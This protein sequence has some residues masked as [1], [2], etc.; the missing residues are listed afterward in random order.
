MPSPFST[1][2]KW[3]IIFLYYDGF[4]TRQVAK[5]L[6]MS[7]FTVKKVLGIYRKWGCI[8]DPWIKK[9]GRRKIFNGNDMKASIF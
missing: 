4:S 1:D 7:R 8:V 6:Y 2:L 3:R 9:T 5:M